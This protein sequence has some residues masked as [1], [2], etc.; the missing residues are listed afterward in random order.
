MIFKILFSFISVTLIGGALGI[1][2]AVAARI[3]AVKKDERVGTVEDILPGVNCGA[4]GYPGCSGYAEGIVN[5]G[6]DITL[7]SPGGSEVLAKIAE[8]MG[9]EADS[10]GEKMVA[11]VHCRGNRD[12]STYKFNYS[13]MDD[14]N[15]MQSMYQGDK[16]CRYGCLAGG[17]CIKVCPVDAITRDSKNRIWVDK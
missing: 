15:A 11:Q 1:G 14:C 12:T 16:E 17:S 6:A 3:L 7:C 5:D 8:I 2:L 10:E 13:G 4:C 9:I